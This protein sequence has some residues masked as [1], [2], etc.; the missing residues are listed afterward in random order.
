MKLPIKK[1]ESRKI[2]CLAILILI[3]FF[4][5]VLTS[6]PYYLHMLIMS[7]IFA[8]NTMGWV[9]ILRV[10]QFSLGQAGFFAIGAYTS[11]L[12]VNRLG[13]S[14]WGAWPLSG[15]TAAMVA[16]IIGSVVLRIK[17]LYFAIVSFAFAEII[18][19]TIISWPKVLGGLDGLSGIPKPRPF[20]FMG[21]IKI[22]FV[23]SRVPF[24]YFLLIIVF[25]AALIFWRVD[26]SR[27][28]RIFR[29][30]SQNGD[31]SES[32]GINL[33]KYR[34]L[35]FTVAC[36]FSGI[37]GGFF[38]HYYGVLHPDS[39]TVSESILIQIQATIGGT[40]S[41]VAGPVLGATVLTILSEFLRAAKHVEPVLYGGILI[42]ILFV[43]P[44]G[45]IDL[46]PRLLRL[47]DK[48]G[49]N[50]KLSMEPRKSLETTVSGLE[51]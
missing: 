9:L 34:V 4:I 40:A 11:A 45:L 16:L 36:F 8:L 25:I 3:L 29:C 41:A 24:Y 51:K 33:M 6:D 39:F 2:F 49:R 17:G 35:A 26:T 43:L 32:L 38:A 1:A 10:G 19:L 46:G 23:T 47:I 15:L 28:G 13:F 18:R 27:L 31:L 22:D 5:P 21:L 50:T 48:K 12:L 7:G 30:V 42:V 44:K 14:F 20:S 37:S